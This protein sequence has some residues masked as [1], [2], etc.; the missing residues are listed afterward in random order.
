MA[1][2]SYEFRQAKA[3]EMKEFFK[4][5]RYVFGD[6]STPSDEEEAKN[7]L[8]AKYTN[9]AFHKGK[10]VATAGGFPFKLRLNG[11]GILA[12]GVTAVGTKPDHRRRGLVRHMITERLQN[13][14]EI[15]QPASILWASMAAIYQRF[16]YGL[17]HSQLFY[18]FDPRYALF[19]R[20][21]TDP[22]SVQL[23][24]KTEAEETV[25]FLYRRYIEDRTLALQRVNEMWKRFGFFTKSKNITY[26]VVH[27]DAHGTPDG[28]L[29]YRLGDY[30][31]RPYESDPDQT[32]NI[33]EYVWLNI[34]A[35]K[36][37]WAF[38]R[39]H[40]LVGQVTL[41]APIDDPAFTLLLEPRIL[42]AT[43]WDG[44]WLRVVD[45]EKLVASRNYSIPGSTIFQ[46]A[47]DKECPW[48]VGTFRLE[49]DGLQAEVEKIEGNCDFS[50][51][52]NGLAS[53]LSGQANLSQL[54]RIGNAEVYK[55]K[56]LSSLDQM[57]STSYAGFCHD[58]F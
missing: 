30:K 38:V 34:D 3:N 5:E 35:Y 17:A 40:D 52:I 53:L 25:P 54:A 10:I 9:I 28:Y 6:N 48:N 49:T 36:A 20:E 14:Y 8:K 23:I 33:L 58:G 56:K 43:L 32:L 7:P 55:T 21:H 47:E 15:G 42:N 1:L 51:T 4:L 29:N 26:T 45:V 44:I 22:G 46:I 39:S 41:N 31:N 11:Q 13:A 27:Y 12:D 18:K 50:I 19:Q 16:G 57:F 37:L 2:S 24:D